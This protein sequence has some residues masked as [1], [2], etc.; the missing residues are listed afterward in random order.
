MTHSLVCLGIV[1]GTISC[2]QSLDDL[3]NRNTIYQFL[4]NNN[5]ESF[6]KYILLG[7]C[8]KQPHS[9]YT[10]GFQGAIAHVCYVLHTDALSLSMY[11]R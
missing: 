9:Y 3:Q 11:V 8:P 5:N 10:L 6:Y 2:V 4:S 1:G 7:Y